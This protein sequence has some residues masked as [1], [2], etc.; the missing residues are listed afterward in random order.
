MA[1]GQLGAVLRHLASQGAAREGERLTD[2]E[3]LR[4][5]DGPG[6]EGAFT[7][8][9]RRHGPMV[10]GTCR[11]ALRD[12][13][14]AEDAFQA[15]FLVLF[16]RA[17]HLDRRGSLAGWLHT[18]A[19]RA[20]HKARS[21]ALRRRRREG[22]AV[23]RPRSGPAAEANGEDL[24]PVLD[25]ELKRLPER[26][27]EPA[28]LCYLEG[29]TNEEAAR[30]LGCPAGTVKSRLARARRLLRTALVRRGVTPALGLSAA[31]ARATVP[32][33]LF[34]AT[35]RSAFRPEAAPAALT[36]ARGVLQTMFR[37]K[38]KAAAG[39]L[40][41]VALALGAGVF[42]YRAGASGPEREGRPALAP[43]AVA[44]PA[45]RQ[46]VEYARL[47][48]RVHDVL[49]EFFEIGYAN[50]YDGRIET[51]PRALPGTRCR[52]LV[53]ILVADDG[54]YEVDV[55][56]WTE[57]RLGGWPAL[58][59]DL[60]GAEATRWGPASRHAGLEALLLRRLKRAGLGDT[61]RLHCCAP[62]VAAPQAGTTATSAPR[63]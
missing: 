48:T 22:L 43:V 6:A 39:L 60:F 36:L 44:A 54:G 61:V 20:A 32:A 40:A 2:G 35:V 11:R 5:L 13:H 25:E 24:R 47:F 15:T 52:A 42:S 37:T 53:S 29:K 12:A 19:L 10:L 51:L 41:F 50:R 28:V 55:I 7:I 57:R 23:K 63:K 45:P 17:R 62:P 16:R 31:Q 1:D 30:L 46:V 38:L 27:R 3:L 56:V 9:V 14:E 33:P 4:Q 58:V 18:V 49:G 21:A 34:Q 26:L 59:L 8:L